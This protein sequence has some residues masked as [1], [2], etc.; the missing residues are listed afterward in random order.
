M[1][2]WS[3]FIL[4]FRLTDL[5]NFRTSKLARYS[6][7]FFNPRSAPV[8]YK[9]M[10]CRNSR[11]VGNFEIFEKIGPKLTR[12]FRSQ[13]QLPTKDQIFPDTAHA[14]MY[15]YMMTF[16]LYLSHGAASRPLLS[17]FDEVQLGKEEFGIYTSLGLRNA[18]LYISLTF[19]A[20]GIH[21]LWMFVI[22]DMLSP[23]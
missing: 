7:E 16:F 19:E 3:P 1:T 17:Y 23:M 6:N 10:T 21:F 13:C 14:D 18:I 9:C 20:T 22:I 11:H 8:L 15:V 2:S 5:C 4:Q 12:I